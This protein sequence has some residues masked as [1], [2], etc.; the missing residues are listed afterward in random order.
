MVRQP[1]FW[2]GRV[3]AWFSCGAASAV[4]AMLAV[5]KYGSRCLVA[6]HDMSSDEHPDN[7][8]FRDEVSSWLGVPIITVPAPYPSVDAVFE[9]TS[10]MASPKGARCSAEMKRVPGNSFAYIED[11]QIFGYP[12]DEADRIKRFQRNNPE[13][14]WEWNLLE[15]GI[16][17]AECFEILRKAGIRR[18]AMYDLGYKNANCFGCVKST[19]PAYWNRVRRDRPDIFELRARRSRELG[20]RLIQVTRNGD[21]QRIFLDELARED[22]GD[23]EASLSCGPFAVTD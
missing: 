13:I 12:A 14:Q 1:L 3:I 6:N 5:D 23:P 7:L 21:R 10:F 20:V 17:K 11:V 2:D 16:T 22:A 15:A 4:A 19:S 9:A 8:R 18:S